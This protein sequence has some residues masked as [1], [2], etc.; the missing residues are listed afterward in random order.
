MV[1]ARAAQVEQQRG[2]HDDTMR[3]LIEAELFETLVPTRWGG[4][5]LDLDTHRQI[6][7]TLS[8]A[9]PSVQASYTRIG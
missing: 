5:G 2:P 8:A 3:E 7:E 6:I 4:H 9:L 1:A